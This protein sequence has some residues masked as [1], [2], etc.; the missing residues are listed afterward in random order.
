M[1]VQFHNHVGSAGVFC[2][3]VGRTYQVM[4]Q[5]G[6]VQKCVTFKEDISKETQENDW[7][8]KTV[9]CSVFFSQLLKNLYETTLSQG[10]GGSQQSIHSF[11]SIASLVTIYP[12]K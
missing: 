3:V 11:P 8:F 2:S 12:I 4:T 9:G 10:R 7:G 1:T 6:D 5:T